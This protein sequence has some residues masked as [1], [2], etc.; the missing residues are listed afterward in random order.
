MDFL[1]FHRMMIG[2]MVYGMVAVILEHQAADL[3]RRL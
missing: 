2:G 3:L 1:T